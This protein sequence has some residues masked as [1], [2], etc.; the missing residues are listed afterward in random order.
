[1]GIGLRYFAVSSDDTVKRWTQAR[2]KR[3]WDGSEPLPEFAGRRL[4]YALVI[5]ETYERE[6]VALRG[7]EWNVMALDPAGKHDRM[8]AMNDAVAVMS[9]V[10]TP[11]PSPIADARRRFYHRR[12]HWEPTRALRAAVIGAALCGRAK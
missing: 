9:A 4:R 6:V 7:V 10:N 12:V 3:V 5:V 11:Y 2:F 8:A 1:M